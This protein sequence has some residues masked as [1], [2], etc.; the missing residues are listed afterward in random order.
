METRCAG[1]GQDDELRMG[2]CF[3]CAS[4]GEER[5]LRR[6]VP[7]HLAK[8]LWNAARCRWGNARID[9]AWAWERLTRT[10]DYAPGGAAGW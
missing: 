1:C 3:D 2:Y 7:G 8:A 5:A 9:L 4:A 6:S 10:G